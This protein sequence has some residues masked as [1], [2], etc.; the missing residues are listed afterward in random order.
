MVSEDVAQ[1]VVTG[2]HGTTFGGN[3]L[4]CRVAHHIFSRLSDPAL[5]SSV[6]EKSEIFQE[7]FQTLRKRFPTHISEVRGHGLILGL[8]LNSDPTPIVT[9]ARERGLLVITCGRDTLRF[10]P[11]LTIIEEEIREGMEVLGEAMGVVWGE[12][13]GEGEKE[14]GEGK[15]KVEGTRGQQ[16]MA[17]EGR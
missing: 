10:V 3:P 7:G 5:Q 16:E 1:C 8:Q 13:M 2:D 11:P 9:A 17:P 6:K 14:G 4:A 15:E 12:G